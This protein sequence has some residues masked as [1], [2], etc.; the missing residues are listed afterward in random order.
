MGRIQINKYTHNIYA[1]SDGGSA[2]KKKKTGMA[3]GECE[4]R[5]GQV[6][7]FNGLLSDSLNEKMT[8]LQRPERDEETCH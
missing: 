8:V 7:N 5:G 1:M 3:N 6:C 2:M 4:G